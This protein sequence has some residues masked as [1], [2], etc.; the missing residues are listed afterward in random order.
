M[1][2]VQAAEEDLGSTS[3]SLSGGFLGNRYAADLLWY[4]EPEAGIRDRL[5]GEL[6]R[7]ALEHDAHFLDV[8][9][10]VVDCGDAPVRMT[11]HTLDELLAPD[12][13][14]FS[15]ARRHG[16]AQVMGCPRRER[17]FTTYGAYRSHHAFLRL[18]PTRERLRTICATENVIAALSAEI[19]HH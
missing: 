2:E 4:R 5:G 14:L 10:A 8:P 17:P 9:V 19:T 18:V 16:P 3:G 15:N 7:P 1:G 13:E 12:A 6:G 11:E